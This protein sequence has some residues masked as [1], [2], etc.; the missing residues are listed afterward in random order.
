MD[1]LVNKHRNIYNEPEYDLERTE[2]LAPTRSEKKPMTT[3]TPSTNPAYNSTR[4]TGM[5]STTAIHQYN[6]SPI[7]AEAYSVPHECSTAEHHSSSA[8]ASNQN[9]TNQGARQDEEEARA[10]A[11]ALGNLI[12]FIIFIIMVVA[13]IV[14]RIKSSDE[15][16]TVRPYE[17]DPLPPSPENYLT[18][19]PVYPPEYFDDP[20]PTIT[21][22]PV[23]STSTNAPSP[24]NATSTPT[25]FSSNDPSETRLV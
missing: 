20:P 8:P 4:S 22:S 21:D 3:K 1:D 13:A 16:Y 6:N 23:S 17:P 11:R 18:S 14:S 7:L 9:Q 12:G 24:T 10:R 2:Y 25:T 15:E 19:W 5:S